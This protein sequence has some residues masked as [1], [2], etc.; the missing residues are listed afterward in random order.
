[1]IFQFEEIKEIAKIQ[2]PKKR[3]D[4]L[5]QKYKD[6]EEYIK[7]DGSNKDTRK[8]NDLLTYIKFLK[9]EVSATQVFGGI[10]T[11]TNL[12]WKI[13][14]EIEKTLGG[15]RTRKNKRKN[16]LTRHKK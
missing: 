1:M 12:G 10:N 2:D 16:K 7:E 11:S 6:I 8:K 4:S 15:R 13:R 14:S 9:R 3:N 5:D